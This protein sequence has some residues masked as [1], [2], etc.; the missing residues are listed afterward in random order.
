[1]TDIGTIDNR[2]YTVLGW[3]VDSTK[4]HDWA[5]CAPHGKDDSG[6]NNPAKAIRHVSATD[7]TRWPGDALCIEHL[8]E[9]G[10]PLYS[11]S[12]T[13]HP[14]DAWKQMHD[15]QNRFTKTW[16]VR[17]YLEVTALAHQR[18]VRLRVGDWAFN[19]TRPD[20]KDFKPE[21]QIVDR[22]VGTMRQLAEALLAACD[23]VE[24]SNPKWAGLLATSVEIERKS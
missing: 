7:M 15:L 23:F 5:C 4:G 16:E 19:F 6:C 17:S 12:E 11:E 2:N 24:Q 1:M 22:N 3:Y 21:P 9:F 20:P 18:N 14:V 8:L 13:S 10:I